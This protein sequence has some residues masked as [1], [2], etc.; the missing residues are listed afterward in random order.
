MGMKITQSDD[1]Y[2]APRL[3]FLFFFAQ[4]TLIEI[5]EECSRQLWAE[6]R[7]RREDWAKLSGPCRARS[8]PKTLSSDRDG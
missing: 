1:Y 6:H 5:R 8:R 4:Q 2:D 3:R 7:H